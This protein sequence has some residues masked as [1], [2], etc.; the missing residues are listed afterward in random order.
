MA[1]RARADER[2]R[3]LH[4]VQSPPVTLFPLSSLLSAE[5]HQTRSRF[6][7]EVVFAY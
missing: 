3:R 2:V 5:Q 4:N 7:A 1:S 6:S